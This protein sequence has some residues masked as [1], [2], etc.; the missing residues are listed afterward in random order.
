MTRVAADRLFV[1][2]MLLLCAMCLFLV[3]TACSG[4]DD[5]DDDDDDDA[6]VLDDDDDD[7]VD[8]DDDSDDDTGDD[9]FTDDD[10]DDDDDD[11]VDYSDNEYYIGCQDYIDT[12]RPTVTESAAEEICS[13][14]AQFSELEPAECVLPVLDD[15]LDC[16]NEDCSDEHWGDCS[17]A[18]VEELVKCI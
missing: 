2:S 10:D 9:D 15:Y 6:S 5:D 13:G 1:L 4:D 12:C 14:F 7:S 3:S 11:T 18:A 17:D 16:I 8:D